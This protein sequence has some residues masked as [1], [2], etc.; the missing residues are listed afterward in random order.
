MYADT[1]TKCGLYSFNTFVSLQQNTQKILRLRKHTLAFML[2][3]TNCA[4]IH[5]CIVLTI[6]LALISLLKI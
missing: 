2:E 3:N 5:L 4:L 1:L 6:S